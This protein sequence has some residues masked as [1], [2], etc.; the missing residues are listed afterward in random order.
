MPE[1]RNPMKSKHAFLVV[2][3]AVVFTGACNLLSDDPNALDAD[4]ADIDA[5]DIGDGVRRAGGQ[6]PDR[7]A[8][9][10]QAHPSHGAA[11]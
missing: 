5:G 11:P 4:T 6:P 2:V 9:V 7:Q 10:A 8:E 3:I 1:G